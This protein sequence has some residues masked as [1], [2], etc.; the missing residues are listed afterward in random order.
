MKKA[1]LA[2]LMVL[3]I[4][5]IMTAQDEILTRPN[6]SGV[7]V[8][9][10]GAEITHNTTVKLTRGL[11]SVVLSGLA[12]NIDRNSINISAKGDIVIMS[13]VQR[14]NFLRP[15]GKTPKIKSLED[16]LES[17]NKSLALNQNENEVLKAEIDLLA[18]NKS[19]G[20]EKIGVSIT[21]L[22][23]MAEFLRKRLAEIKNKQY[24]LSLSAKKIQKNIERIQNQLTELNNSL[25]KSTNEIVISVLAK[26]AGEAEFNLSY[27]SY[28][29]GWQPAY[30]IRV[31]KLD[32]P[33]ALSYKANVWQN[34][35]L[36]WN[37]ASIVLSTRNPSSENQKPELNTWFLD[38]TRPVLY[39]GI[40]A[41]G[42]KAQGMNAQI[43]QDIK[44]KPAATMAD[45]ISVSDKQLSVE[46]IPQIKYTIPTDNKPH[47]VSLREFSI[48]AYYEY[49]A[50]PKLSQNGFLIARL[51]DWEQYDLLPGRANLYFE[52]S[53][54]GQ[55][56]IDP[57][58]TKD[59]L[60]ISLGRDQN[61]LVSRTVLKDFS[62]DKFLSSNVGRTFAYE[63]KIRDN[64]KIKIKIAV[65][66]Q[67]PVSKNEDI[68]VKLIDS[69]GALYNAETGSLKWVVELEAGQ[70][71]SR[72]L[73]YSVK[74]PKD[75][76]VPGL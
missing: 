19:I 11:N 15:A 3:T 23:K 4:S 42:R 54:V 74:Y 44:I 37:D 18:A 75:K 56:T 76:T 20:N 73:V 64:K 12:N 29:A 61:I 35:G 71:V 50:L 1:L 21:E 46:F 5:S 65:E 58:T 43:T 2:L 52:N 47:S 53:F 26:T 7:K 14:F 63:I 13:I 9:M 66:D 40:N 17:E 45:Y 39:K 48:P 57:F 41:E 38:F 24:D 6:I 30:D 10:R 33:A 62:E 27:L 51:T 8:Y 60:T 55:S 31:S 25:N 59:T 36:D 28:D 16:S 49:S 68:T 32:S 72:K 34:T 69:S 70:S 22:Q 67:V